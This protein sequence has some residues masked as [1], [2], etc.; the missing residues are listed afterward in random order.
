MTSA[1]AL[2]GDTSLFAT[3]RNATQLGNSTAA[4]E[5][6]QRICHGGAAIDMPF[7]RMSSYYGLNYHCREVVS[8]ASMFP[9]ETTLLRLANDY[10]EWVGRASALNVATFFAGEVLLTSASMLPYQ[11]TAYASGIYSSEGFEILRPKRSMAAVI[12]VSALVL[13]QV[14]GVVGLLAYTVVRPREA[15]STPIPMDERVVYKA[16]R[17]GS[18]LGGS[19]GQEG[20]S[21]RTAGVVG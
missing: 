14:I 3:L 7:A 17:E 9:T 16:S 8:G 21:T 5:A 19:A 13:V 4:D 6:L 10:V 2:F 1:L 15:M 18:E 12:V 11:S 20:M